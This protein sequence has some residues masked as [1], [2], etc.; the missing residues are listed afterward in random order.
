MQRGGAMTEDIG[1]VPP[2]WLI[3]SDIMSQWGGGLRQQ[4]WCE[5]I[6]ARGQPV[7]LFHIS[8]AFSVRWSDVRSVEE[9]RE[10]RRAWIAASPPR[11]GVRDTRFARLARLLKHTLL[12]DLVAP[13]VFRT[14]AILSAMLKKTQAPVTL[15]CSSPPFAMAVIGRMMKALHGDRV[16]V[17][18]DMRDLWSLHT[19]LPGPKFHKRVV[20]RWVVGGADIFTT[21][22]GELASRFKA[23]F[24]P[25]PQVVFNIA[26]HVAPNPADASMF[27]WPGLA[28]GLRA[29]TRKIV[30]TGS[31]PADFYDLDGLLDAVELFASRPEARM[32][33][34][35]FVG[36]GGELAARTGARRLPPNLI[37]FVPQMTQK[38]VAYVQS[39][40]DVLMFLGYQS[41][42]NQGQV[43]IKLFE[44]FRRQRPILPVHIRKGSDVDWL[45][46]RY[47]GHCPTLLSKGEMVDA[48]VRIGRG[49]AEAILPSA[50]APLA[51]D[52]DL[53][54]AYQS[55]G[56]QIV[57]RYRERLP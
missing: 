31:I 22:A 18:L 38:S 36:A 41:C 3:S 42:D 23:A 54:T 34:F 1:R 30:Y 56:D 5:Y 24:G 29:D 51:V 13:S 44:Y 47:C 40:A 15:M 35:V 6:L 55:V 43:S 7:R 46:G 19:A 17:H 53:L 21:V 12:P 4:R 50:A 28:P 52:A 37:T 32:V 45:I 33:Q 25:E 2:I 26:T 27:D 9:L 39:A 49:E 10:K 57:A 14:I 20:E 8:G 16:V 48:F 11:A